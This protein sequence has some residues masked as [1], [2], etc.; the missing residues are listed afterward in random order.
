MEVRRIQKG[1][2]MLLRD[3]RLKAL[4]ESPFAFGAKLSDEEIT[5]LKEFEK[6]ADLHATS[7]VS[8]TFFAF[9]EKTVVGQIGAFIDK[10]DNAFICAMWVSPSDRRKG[11]GKKLIK[12]AVAWLNQLDHNEVYAWVSDENTTAKDFYKSNG[13]IATNTQQ[14][15][16]SSANISETLYVITKHG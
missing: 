9:D 16:P 5:P 12:A 8:T 7:E 13:F 15:L 11:I 6:K 14:P 1:Q 10:S 4:T 2:G 3:V